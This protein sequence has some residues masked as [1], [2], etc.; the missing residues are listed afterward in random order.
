MVVTYR[1]RQ[2]GLNSGEVWSGSFNHY[3]RRTTWNA[4]YLEDTT[5]QQQQV[6]QDGGFTFLGVDPVTGEVNAN[7][8]PGDLIVVA[9]V[10]P[11]QSLTNEVV[12][13]KR[14]SGTFGMKTG[15]TGLRVTVFDE[16]RRYLTSLREEDTKGISA[17]LN[18]RLAPRTNGILSGTYQR[19]KDNEDGGDLEDVYM[20]IRADVTRQMSRSIFGSVAYQLQR[21]DS[22]EN[23]RDYTENRIEARLT[24]LF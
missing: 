16:K 15:K 2:V 5:T 8:Q 13:R 6:L 10:G 7:P 18:R 3:T 4:I 1:D 14:A 23:S 24:K 12:E 22:N 11:V 21:Q 17:S 9:P 20:Y 19:I